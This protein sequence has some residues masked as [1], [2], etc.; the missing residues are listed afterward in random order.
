MNVP[1]LAG[2]MPD[3]LVCP[4]IGRNPFVYR[5][6]PDG[7]TVSARVGQTITVEGGGMLMGYYTA[8]GLDA[9][10]GASPG[11]WRVRMK[12]MPLRLLKMPSEDVL[13]HDW[14]IQTRWSTRTYYHAGY[15]RT[16]PHGRPTAPGGS[17]HAYADGSVR[18]H[19]FSTFNR[20]AVAQNNYDGGQTHQVV[21]FRSTRQLNSGG[22]P[23]K[24]NYIAMTS[25]LASHWRGMSKD[26]QTDKTHVWTYRP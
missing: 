25:S 23:T 9:W 21:P 12:S 8:L 20:S 6:R 1:S 18:W 19:P 3:L 4:S 10:S 26:G 22:Y 14:M 16:T 5:G 15:M 11:Y 17:N 2:G 13:L 7:T 24:S